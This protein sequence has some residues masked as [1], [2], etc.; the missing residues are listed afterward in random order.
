MDSPFL[1]SDP[2]RN[3]SARLLG[4][5]TAYARDG[6]GG[7]ITG[8]AAGFASRQRVVGELEVEHPL[9]RHAGRCAQKQSA[10]LSQPRTSGFGSTPLADHPYERAEVPGVKVFS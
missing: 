10:A 3:G 7:N 1:T 5:W 2:W 8:E 9:T 6:H 4:R